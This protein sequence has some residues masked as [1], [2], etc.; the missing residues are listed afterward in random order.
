MPV[1]EAHLRTSSVLW[2]EHAPS[3]AARPALQ[4]TASASPGH[5]SSRVLTTFCAKS[6]ENGR[7]AARKDGL[8][9]IAAQDAYLSVGRVRAFAPQ[10]PQPWKLIPRKPR[11]L[12]YHAHLW[13]GD[14]GTCPGFLPTRHQAESFLQPQRSLP[15]SVRP[16]FASQGCLLEAGHPML[17]QGQLSKKAKAPPSPRRPSHFYEGFVICV[18]H[19]LCSLSE[20]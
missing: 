14:P 19:E 15:S 17:P 6:G 11:S 13:R 3:Q 10:L 18:F 9:N 5:P 8:A 12:L 20:R 16:G 4:N 1:S 7:Q 2:E